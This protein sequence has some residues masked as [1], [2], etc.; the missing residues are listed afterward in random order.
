LRVRPIRPEDAAAEV[1]FVAGLSDESRYLRFM[2][3]LHELTP[4][5]LAR[6]T[7]VDYDRELALIALAGEL[8]AEKI[9]GVARYVANPD[10]E[11]A[12]FAVVVADAW[13]GRGLG[14]ALMGKLIA[15]AKRRGFRRLVGTILGINASMLKLAGAL[16][17]RLR[18]DADDPEQLIAELDLLTPFTRSTLSRLAPSPRNAGRGLG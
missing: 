10:R 7:Q 17:F 16:G 5:M 15:S 8:R 9:V 4:Q 6:F 1:A 14:R 3:H 13:Q 18:T 2:Y 12:E 11:S